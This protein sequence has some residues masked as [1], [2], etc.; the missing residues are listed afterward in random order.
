MFSLRTVPEINA[1]WVVHGKLWLEF[2]FHTC[3]TFQVLIAVTMNITVFWDVTPYTVVRYYQPI[4]STFSVEAYKPILFL[5]K[6]PLF[7][8]WKKPVIEPR[9]SSP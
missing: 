2:N 8:N 6:K 9:L 1:E 4:T 7:N 5:K 3:L